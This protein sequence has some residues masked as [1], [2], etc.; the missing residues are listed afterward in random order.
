ME[1]FG[2]FYLKS[3]ENIPL[4]IIDDQE[5]VCIKKRNLNVKK[6]LF[7]VSFSVIPVIK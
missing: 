4:K 3:H 2:L 1:Y 6:N 7:L 5:M